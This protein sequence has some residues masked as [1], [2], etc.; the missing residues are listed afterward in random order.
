[1]CNSIVKKT[2]YVTGENERRCERWYQIDKVDTASILNGA[3]SYPVEVVMMN[4]SLWQWD[5][6]GRIH[7]AMVVLS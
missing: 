5:I 6:D 1:M 7:F 4:I 2:T 3:S